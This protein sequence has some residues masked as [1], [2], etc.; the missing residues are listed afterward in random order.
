MKNKGGHAFIVR[1]IG[2]GTR[3]SVESNL[4]LHSK[5]ADDSQPQ[6]LL[7]ESFCLVA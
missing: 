6:T 4:D 7:R 1:I 5:Q 2:Q 3:T